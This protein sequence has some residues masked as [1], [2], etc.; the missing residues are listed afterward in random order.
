MWKNTCH[1]GAEV[2]NNFSFFARALQHN[3]YDI[4]T[5]CHGLNDDDRAILTL[6]TDSTTQQLTGKKRKEA[7]QQEK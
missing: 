5:V 2:Y 3:E 4:E 1:D 6:H 7:T